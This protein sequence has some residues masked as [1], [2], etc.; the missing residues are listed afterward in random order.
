MTDSFE[1]MGQ[2]TNPLW[3]QLG[4]VDDCILVNDRLAVP[5]QL[6]S[7]VLKRTHRGHLG[8][9]AMLNVT[10]YLWWSHMHKDIVNLAEK[11]RSC[12]RYGKNAKNIIPKNA[13]KTLPLLTQ[14]EQELQLDYAGPLKDHKV[15]KIYLLVAIDRYSKFPSVKTTK[16][17]GGKSSIK[18]LRTYIDTYGK[19]E[20]IKTDQFIGFKGKAMKKFCSEDNIEQKCCPMGDHRECGLL[21]QQTIE[22]IKRRLRVLLLDENITSIKLC[23]STIN[24]TLDGQNKK[25]YNALRLK[26]TLDVFQKQ[27]LKY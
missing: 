11:C 1:L 13:T 26:L 8:Q 6:R 5:C 22:I 27:S 9:E 24:E 14:P 2:Y 7:A 18:F 20:S 23:L 3:Q 12:N 10:H 17:T 15:K 21:E 16:S 25:P 4:V 19:P